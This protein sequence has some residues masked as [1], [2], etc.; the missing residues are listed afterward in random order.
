MLQLKRDGMRRKS[1]GKAKERLRSNRGNVVII[2]YNE[3]T[4]GFYN[5][6]NLFI[7]YATETLCRTGKVIKEI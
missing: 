7:P 3:G 4:V 1:V 6:I 2:G 5:I